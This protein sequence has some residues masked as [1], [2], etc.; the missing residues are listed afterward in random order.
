MID[1]SV[2]I[3]CLNE[4]KTVGIC[5]E[6]VQKVFKEHHIDGEVIIVDNKSTDKSI[7]V[8]RA[9]GAKVIIE[10]VR[11][12]GSA[13]LRGFREAQGKY[14]IMGDADNTYDFEVIHEFLII[15]KDQRYDLV[16]ATRLKGKILPGA[17]PWLHRY[18]GNPILTRFFNL[19]F[20]TKF[21]DVLSGYKAFRKEA[22]KQ[23]EFNSRN[24][25]FTVEIMVKAVTAKLRIKEIPI[26]YYPRAEGSNTKLHSF[27]DGWR[28]FKF[29]ASYLPRW[30]KILISLGCIIVILLLILFILKGF[31]VI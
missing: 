16:T 10:E 3:P 15:L 30:V 18:I 7:D 11:G 29:I 24:M 23:I 21:S 8:A 28:Y 14:I 25:V 6:K 13:Y 26:T 1:V 2:V 27:R 20:G 5:V 22:L 31:S 19:L 12:Y 17:M 9:K 4:E